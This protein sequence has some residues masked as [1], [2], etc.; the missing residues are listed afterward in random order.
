MNFCL[1]VKKVV[2]VMINRIEMYKEKIDLLFV[3]KEIILEK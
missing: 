1:K 3:K 2:D